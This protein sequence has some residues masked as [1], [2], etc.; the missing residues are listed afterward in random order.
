MYA[1]FLAIDSAVCVCYSRQSIIGNTET[2]LHYSNDRGGR[3]RAVGVVVSGRGGKYISETSGD[4][5]CAIYIFLFG[6]FLP[7]DLLG[8]TW[9]RSSERT[10]LY[11]LARAH[12]S[13]LGD[14]IITLKWIQLDN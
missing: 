12:S 10:R 5:C 1:F 9:A 14:G 2:T 13:K 7:F 11:L 8:S 6:R 3:H 4:T